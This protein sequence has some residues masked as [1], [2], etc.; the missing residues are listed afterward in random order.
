MCYIIWNIKQC[1]MES[2]ALFANWFNIRINSDMRF[3]KKSA[4]ILNQK[5]KHKIELQIYCMRI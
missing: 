3:G 1:G 2:D 4:N 5:F